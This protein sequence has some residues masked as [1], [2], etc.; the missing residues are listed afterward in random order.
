VTPDHYGLDGC[1][2][3]CRHGACLLP[4]CQACGCSGGL[5]GS[6]CGTPP[7]RPPYRRDRFVHYYYPPAG[8]PPPPLPAAFY[9]LVGFWTLWFEPLVSRGTR[10]PDLGSPLPPVPPVPLYLL[11]GP[12]VTTPHL[13]GYRC[14]AICGTWSGWLGDARFAT[15]NATVEYS[16]HTSARPFYRTTLCVAWVPAPPFSPSLD[17][18]HVGLHHYRRANRALHLPSYA[19]AD[20]TPRHPHRSRTSLPRA[21]PPVMVPVP[22]SFLVNRIDAAGRYPHLRTT[23]PFSWLIGTGAARLT[24]R[25]RWNFVGLQ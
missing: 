16:H 5:V 10:H 23:Q 2:R 12:D 25:Y 21:A 8:Y 17:D 24:G 9:A 20:L 1:Q 7:P 14:Y 6:H 11:A 3:D 19:D 13:G 18:G 4:D 22:Y 15:L